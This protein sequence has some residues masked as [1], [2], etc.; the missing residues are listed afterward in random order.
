MSLNFWQFRKVGNE[1]WLVQPGWPRKTFVRLFGTLGVHARIRNGRMINA[2]ARLGLPG[3]AE[4]LDAGC[5]HAYSTFWFAQRFP[6]QTF[7]AIELDPQLVDE[8][9]RI[10]QALR[11]NNICFIKDSITNLNQDSRYHLIFS[12]DVLEHIEDDL[13]VLRAFR[14]ALRPDGYLLLHLP[15]RHQEH[16]RIFNAFKDH[17]VS[18]HVRDE[19]TVAE[20]TEK[21]QKTGFQV[22]Y[23]RYGFSQWGELAFELN[24]LFWKQNILRILA[25]LLFHPLSVWLA[26]MDTRKDYDDGNSLLILARP[27]QEQGPNHE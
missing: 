19:Y 8:G 10:S 23:A 4:I 15:R 20:I 2:I 14:K 27:K 21:L 7:T 24:Y 12:I 18:D 13:A 6:Q 26:Y 5:G 25:A 22:E 1:Q 9:Q 11:L 3:N 17:T 16:R